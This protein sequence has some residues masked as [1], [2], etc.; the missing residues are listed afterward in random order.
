MCD[1]FVNGNFDVIVIGSGPA[2][3][4]CARY[5]AKDGFVVALVD[6]ERFPR[7]KP[8]GGAFSY[9]LLDTFPYLRKRE[10]EII[11]SVSREGTIYSP[12]RR[13]A[14]TGKVELAMTMR[15]DFDKVLHED[16]VDQG[17]VPLTGRRVKS[18]QVSSDGV[19]AVVSDG[20]I[21]RGRVLVGADGVSSTVAR[22]LGFRKA[23]P[24]RSITACRV[25]EVPVKESLISDM[26]GSRRTYRFYANL[27]NEPGYGWVFPKRDT[28]NVGLGI[29]G[30]ESKGL[31]GKFSDFL[32]MLLKEGLLPANPDLSGLRGALV[33]TG[34]PSQR[35]YGERC[36]LVGD[37]CGMVN[38]LTGGGIAYSM[39][40]ARYAAKTLE[41]CLESDRLGSTVLMTYQNLWR[42]DFGNG[43]RNLLAAQR[44]FTSPL[45]NLLFEIGSRDTMLQSFV[46]DAMAESNE[47][48]ISVSRLGSRLLHVLFREAFHLG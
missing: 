41:G 36:I 33:P 10:P 31:P 43:M 8:C 9:G 3:S 12:N 5:L 45:T 29:V 46:A 27:N 19:S 40:A 18:C 22:T 13:V 20:L 26:Y 11:K 42:S 16:A 6:R 44:I 2:G 23:W 38:P 35:S 14:L 34:G 47:H 32:H 28:V 39:R 37:A 21:I 24:K 17:A 1:D 7:D 4:T 30:A 15:S 48:S 25:A